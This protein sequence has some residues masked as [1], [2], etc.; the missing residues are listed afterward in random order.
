MPNHELDWDFDPSMK[1]QIGPYPAE[2]TGIACA[3]T[4]L[5]WPISRHSVAK[6]AVPRLPENRGVP[7]SSP[8]LATAERP[9]NSVLFVAEIHVLV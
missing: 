3:S 6:T 9:C 5:E 1:S 8:G 7:G 2:S 4:I